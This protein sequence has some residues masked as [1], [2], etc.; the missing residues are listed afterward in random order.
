MAEKNARADK[1]AILVVDDSMGN[2]LFAQVL[3]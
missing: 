3:L 2:R 1:P